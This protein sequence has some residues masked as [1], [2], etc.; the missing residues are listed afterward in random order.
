MLCVI[1][2]LK[3]TSATAK[4]A[5]AT[6]KSATSATVFTSEVLALIATVLP[7]HIA[8]CLSG[9]TVA[10]HVQT[11]DEVHHHVGVDAVVLGVAA[12]VG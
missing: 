2:R 6:T 10:K 11:I 4:A 7:A 1:F 3:T 5:S 9:L 8:E 12:A